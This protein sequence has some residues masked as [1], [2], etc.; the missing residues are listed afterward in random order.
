MKKKSNLILIIFVISFFI[1]F[2]YESKAQ[3]KP[4]YLSGEVIDILTY[5]MTGKTGTELKKEILDSLNLCNPLGILS[6][7]KIYIVLSDSTGVK[8]ND[9]LAPFYGVKIRAKGK[10]YSKAG[11]NVLIPQLVDIDMKSK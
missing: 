10:I 8:P 5:T 1:T 2:K 4:Q 11:L 7:G 9:Y 3:Q 6:G